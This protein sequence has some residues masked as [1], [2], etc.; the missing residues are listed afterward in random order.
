MNVMYAFIPN[1]AEW[2]DIEYYTDYDRMEKRLIKYSQ[3]KGFPAGFGMM[4]SAGDDGRM[5]E[6]YSYHINENFQVYKTKSGNAPTLNQL[7]SE[8]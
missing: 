3:R 7:L 8:S 2:E 1:G 4:Y 6:I 5:Y